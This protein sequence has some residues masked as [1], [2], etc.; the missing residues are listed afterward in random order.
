MP[1]IHESDFIS[2]KELARIVEQG[3]KN[4]YYTGWDEY[5]DSP[6]A[7]YRKLLKEL[8]YEQDDRDAAKRDYRG[9]GARN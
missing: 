6:Y 3:G 2:S 7:Q 4:L 5:K 8:G 9:F 1:T